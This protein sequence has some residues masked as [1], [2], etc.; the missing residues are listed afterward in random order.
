MTSTLQ[1]ATWLSAGLLI[2]T[3]SCLGRYFSRSS[4]VGPAAHTELAPPINNSALRIRAPTCAFAIRDSLVREHSLLSF[5]ARQG[6]HHD[7]SLA[8]LKYEGAQTLKV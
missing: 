2:S 4:T 7:V 6:R 5:S 8:S 1:L 3:P